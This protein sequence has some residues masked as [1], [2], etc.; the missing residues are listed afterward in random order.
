MGFGF[1]LVQLDPGT[2]LGV[3]HV[4]LVFL[5]EEYCLLWGFSG[6]IGVRVERLGLMI[7][8]LEV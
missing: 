2:Q 4:D 7:R 8:L 3:V 6:G 1:V 5:V